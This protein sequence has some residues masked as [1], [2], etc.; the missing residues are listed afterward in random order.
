LKAEEANET[1]QILTDLARFSPTKSAFARRVMLA[2][3][4]DKEVDAHALPDGLPD[5][6]GGRL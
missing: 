6:G 3:S 4:F 5:R 1:T 2:S